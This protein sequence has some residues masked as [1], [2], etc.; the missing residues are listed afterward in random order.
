MEVVRGWMP[1]DTDLE[2]LGRYVR[3]FARASSTTAALKKRDGERGFLAS[4]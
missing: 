3:F 1:S 4:F 2:V